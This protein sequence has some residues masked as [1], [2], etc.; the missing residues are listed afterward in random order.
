MD[1]TMAWMV[2]ALVVL[3][4]VFCAVLTV[5][6]FR[7]GGHKTYYR[8]DLDKELPEIRRLTKEQWLRE[9]VK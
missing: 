9:R 1:Y 3:A 4:G 6:M 7:K 8:V 5:E 2:L